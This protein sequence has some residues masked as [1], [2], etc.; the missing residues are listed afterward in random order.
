MDDLPPLQEVLGNV[1]SPPTTP[2]INN[3]TITAEQLTSLIE[4][5]VN[6]ALARRDALATS[7]SSLVGASAV[8]MTTVPEKAVSTSQILSI[9]SLDTQIN[10]SSTA[11]QLTTPPSIPVQNIYSWHSEYVSQD[12]YTV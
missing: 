5:F 12:N 8:E 10:Q 2:S 4:S 7:S 9:F 11:E 1:Q 3:I 6:S